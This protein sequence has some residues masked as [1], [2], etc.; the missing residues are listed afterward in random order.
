M[1]AKNEQQKM[2]I[3]FDHQ[4]FTLQSYGGI[5]RYFVRLIQGLLA[6]G[7]EAN[8]IVPLHRNRYLKELPDARVHGWELNR[9]PPKTT[10]LF[11]AA[12]RQFGARKMR[13]IQPELLHETYYAAKP[14]Q[15]PVKARILTVYDM[16]HEKF[17]DEFSAN[18][19]TSR[20]K[21]AAVSRADHIVCISHSTKNDLCHLFDV[22]A[23]KI[24]V[25][26]LG[27]EKFD[28][29]LPTASFNPSEPPFLLYVGNR[30]GYKNFERMLRAI[31]SRPEL[32]NTFH[33]VAFGGSPFNSRERQLIDMLGFRPTAVQQIGGS[34]RI[35]GGLYRRA[36]A[37]IYPSLYEGFGLPPLEAMAHECPVVSSNTSSM[38]EVIGPACEY[39]D[40]A[41][42]DA[43]AEAI[44]KVVFDER[45]RSELI[46]EGKE[47]L[48]LFSWSRCA[49]ETHEVYQRALLLKG[50]F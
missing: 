16:I 13:A 3:A 9:F 50:A 14:L 45:R 17:T 44:A 23:H 19:P 4:I 46:L 42:I 26:H 15:V 32:M 18:D 28:D 37:F 8:V 21:R 25:V 12:N 2:K 7:E 33:V 31:A 30:G 47:R 41:D 24:S 38:P 27:F 20:N 29:E 35:L 48:H 49:L 5:S 6:L 10:R 1:I 39:F 43:Q 40:P 36:A 22:P 11:A 34:D